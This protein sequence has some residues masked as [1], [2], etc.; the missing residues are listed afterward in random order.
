MILW[1]EH[2]G[3]RW[4]IWVPSGRSRFDRGPGWAGRAYG[5]PRGEMED[6]SLELRG[7]GLGWKCRAWYGDAGE[8]RAVGELL[9]CQ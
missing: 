7:Q 5:H 6:T 3:G 9:R 4:G 1:P 8:G 2:L